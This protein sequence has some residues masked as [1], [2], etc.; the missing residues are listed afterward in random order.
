MPPSSQEPPISGSGAFSQLKP[1]HS[2]QA[3]EHWSP[4]FLQLQVAPV[5]SVLQL[6][7]MTSRTVGGAG[8]R[9]ISIGTSFPSTRCQ[10]NVLDSGLPDLTILVLA[11]TLWHYGT[12]WQRL[13]GEEHSDTVVLCGRGCRGKH[14]RMHKVCTFCNLLTKSFM[15]KT[16]KC[17]LASFFKFHFCW[18]FIAENSCMFLNVWICSS[19]LQRSDLADPKDTWCS[20]SPTL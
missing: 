7:L 14:L 20:I 17:S 15:M 16:I 3:R 12:L 6:H 1:L 19:N 13:L 9:S 8:G 5:Q 18:S 11:K 2:P 10:P 4:C